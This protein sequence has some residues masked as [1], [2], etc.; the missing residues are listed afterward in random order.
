PF[1]TICGGTISYIQALPTRTVSKKN[2][3]QCKRYFYFANQHY[4]YALTKATRFKAVLTALVA[5]DSRTQFQLT[6]ILKLF[7]DPHE[8]LFQIC[9]RKP[10]EYVPWN[11]HENPQITKLP[12]GRL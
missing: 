9:Q 5:Q 10:I 3:E 2:Q 7:C 4:K 11:K 8:M 6:S 1:C 12:F